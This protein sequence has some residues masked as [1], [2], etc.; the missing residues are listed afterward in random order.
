MRRMFVH[1]TL[2]AVLLSVAVLVACT[3]CTATANARLLARETLAQS[4]EYEDSVRGVL[5]AATRYYE[6]TIRDLETRAAVQRA[7]EL[8]TRTNRLAGDAVDDI[9]RLGFRERDFRNF[10]DASVAAELDAA[11]AAT[12]ALDQMRQRQKTL[13]DLLTAQEKSLKTLRTRLETLQ[14]EPSFKDVL[15][16]LR[17]LFDKARDVIEKAKKP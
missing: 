3:S 7:T 17:P 15:S 10:I 12:T 1:K 9:L 11:A 6:G 8:K 14:S 4:T 13:V 2:G 5:R 16:D